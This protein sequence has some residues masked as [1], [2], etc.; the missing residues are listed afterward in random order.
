MKIFISWSGELSHKIAT[1]LKEWLQDVIQS[2]DAYVS[3][4]DIDKGS[5]WVTN[6]AGELENTDFGIVCLTSD[7][8]EAPWI[9]FESGALSKSIERS[10]ISAAKRLNILKSLQI[11]K[12]S[13]RRKL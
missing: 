4:K 11:T 9:L 10:A 12:K 5:R 1:I 13:L 2:V 3:S 7:N 6:I 8:L